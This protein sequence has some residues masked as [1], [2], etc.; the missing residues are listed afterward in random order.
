MRK[1]KDLTEEEMKYIKE[2]SKKKHGKDI[3][4]ALSIH[5]TTLLMYCKKN[6]LKY[7]KDDRKYVTVAISDK[8]LKECNCDLERVKK[9]IEILIKKDEIEEEME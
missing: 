4:K 1:I 2:N 8:L 5:A 9:Y 3:A 6:N 7:I